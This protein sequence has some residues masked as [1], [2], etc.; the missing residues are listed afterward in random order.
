MVNSAYSL[1]LILLFNIIPNRIIVLNEII[2]R[3]KGKISGD[4]AFKLKDTYGFPIEE[5]LLLAKDAMLDVD[6]KK[7]YHLEEEAKKN[8]LKKHLILT[9]NML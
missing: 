5:I 3:S 8:S 9:I 2:E 1:F 6:L 7:F 4:D